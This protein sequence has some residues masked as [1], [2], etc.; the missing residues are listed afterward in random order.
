MNEY[1]T[2]K[3]QQTV[4]HEQK[5]MIKELLTA[6]D[7]FHVRSIDPLARER[8]RLITALYQPI[9]GYKATAIYQEL[10]LISELSSDYEYVSHL[11]LLDRLSLDIEEF[12]QARI[13]LE[14]IGLLKTWGKQEQN[15]MI[16]IYELLPAI[17]S[18]KFFEDD[19]L[20]TMLLESVGKEHFMRLYQQFYHSSVPMEGFSDM[21]HS[22]VQSFSFQK[23]I[24]ETDKI[25]PSLTTEMTAPKIDLKQLDQWDWNFFKDLMTQSYI[26]DQ[27][28]TEDVLQLIGLYH[29]MYGFSELELYQFIE[30]AYDYTTQTINLKRFKKLVYQTYH[31]QQEQPIS[32]IAESAQDHQHPSKESLPLEQRVNTLKE[33]YQDSIV[34]L[35]ISAEQYTPAQ[36]I[37]AIKSQQNKYVTQQ[38]L[39][40]IESMVKHSKLPNSVINI[41]I[42]YMLVVKDAPLLEDKYVHKIANRWAQQSITTPEAAV[43]MIDQLVQDANKGS[44]TFNRY[45]NSQPT[46]QGIVPDWLKED[47]SESKSSL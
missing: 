6:K 28:F 10:L 41:L 20:K 25:A 40:L 37:Y 26:A 5:D 4:H 36:F 46:A 15:T 33:K 2:E 34:Q 38:E 39:W 16:Y 21:T 12:Y 11:E 42:H 24:T 35:I 29:H 9:I 13:K 8:D 45:Y 27:L 31:Q 7:L 22:F 18:F 32:V 1:V 43:D 44:N 14:G 3:H 23:P 30:Q 19:I 17:S 47:L